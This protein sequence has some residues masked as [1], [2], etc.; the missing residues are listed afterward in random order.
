MLYYLTKGIL[1]IK[2]TDLTPQKRILMYS[3]LIVK[4]YVIILS[5]FANS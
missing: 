5:A 2:R 3:H 1:H 4:K